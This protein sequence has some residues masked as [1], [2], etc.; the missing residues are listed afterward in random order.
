MANLS[1]KEIIVVDNTTIDAVFSENLNTS[2]GVSNITIVSDTPGV[3]DPT[4]S[5]VKV[6]NNSLRIRTTPIGY[7]STYIITFKSTSF[8]Q[9]SNKNKTA[10][11]PED[12]TNN[13]RQFQGPF[14]NDNAILQYLKAFFQDSI[15][16]IDNDQ[17]TTARLTQAY[18]KYL[19]KA[20]YDIRQV[21]N[22]NY[23]SFTVTDEQ[24]QRGN[25]PY[26][27]L[28]EEAAYEILRVG[29]TPTSTKSTLTVEYDEFPSY[30]ITLG[31]TSTSENLS[32]DS[33]DAPGKFNI[34]NFTL[35]LL[36]S[37]VIKLSSL[38]FTY[39]A[40]SYVYNVETY[41]YQL[42]NNKYAQDYGFKLYTLS[43]SQIKI[44]DKILED[45]NF[46][47]DGILNIQATYLYN[48]LG[49]EVNQNTLSVYTYFTQSREVI[50]PIVNTFQLTYAPIVGSG[51]LPGKIG[52]VTFID[53]N[54]TSSTA[55]HPAFLYEILYRLDF[56]PSKPGEYCVEYSTGKVYVYGE[57]YK[58][59]GT[60]PYPPL[61]TYTYKYDFKPEI[62]YVFD[63]QATGEENQNDFVAL[64]NGSLVEEHGIVTIEHEKVLV[65]NIDFV[66]NLHKESLNERIN[67]NLLS[68]SII[69]AAN[70]P[71]TNVFRVYNETSGEVYRIQRFEDDKIYVNYNNPPSILQQKR[72][73]AK[74]ET[75]YNELIF[76]SSSLTNASTIKVF[77]IL[78]NSSNLAS[79]S[80]DHI[81][82]FKNTPVA[83][84]KTEIFE[85]EKWYNT[86]LTETQN[87]N[88]LT[89]IGEYN[90]NYTDGILYIAV[91]GSQDYNLG[92]LS[93]KSSK[94]ELEHPHIISPDDIYTQINVLENKDKKYSYTSFEDKYILPSQLTISDEQFLNNDVLYPYQVDTNEIGV[95]D[96]VTF[97]AGVTDNIK[98]I[99]GIYEYQDILSSKSPFNFANYSTFTNNLITLSTATISSFD[100]VKYD[101]YDYYVELPQELQYISANITYTVSVIRQSDSAELWDLSGV[102]NT[103]D[104]VR[105]VLSG[106]NSPVVDQ[107]VSVILTLTI[108]DVSRVV[109]DYDKGELYLDYTYLNDEILINYEYGDNILD[110]RNS[111]SLTSGDIYYVSYKVGALRDALQRNFATLLNIDELNSLNIDFDR[112]RYR[113]AIYAAL[114]SFSQGPTLNAIKNIGHVISHI[115]PEV[116]ESI[117]QNWSLGNSLLNPRNIEVVGNFDLVPVKYGQGVLINDASQ[118]MTFPM[119]SNLKLEGGTFETWVLPQWYGLD[120]DGKLDFEI[121]KDGYDVDPLDIFLGANE[122]HPSSNDFSIEKKDIL[123]GIPNLNK[124]GVYIYYDRDST[125]SYYR[126]NVQ[127]IDGYIDGYSFGLKDYNINIRSNGNFYDVKSSALITPVN[128]KFTTGKNF[129]KYMIDDGYQINDGLTF[130]CDVDHYI[131]DVGKEYNKNR[132]S[133]F[134]DPSGYI[135]FRVYDKFGYSYNLSSDVSSW[136]PN[137]LHHI[138]ASWKLNT[139]NNKDEMHLFIDGTEVPNIIKYGEKVVP[140]LHQNFRTVSQE[141]LIALVN[142]DII[143]GTDLVTTS[144]LNTVS[145]LTNFGAYNILVGDTIHIDE[146]GFSTSGY[147]ISVIAGQNLTLSSSM[148]LSLTDGKFTINRTS[149][150]VDSQINIYPNIAV[151]TLSDFYTNT[152]GYVNTG[153]STITTSTNLAT[154]GVEAGNLVRL[155][156]SGPFE[157]FYTVVSVGG[158]NL[159]VN[160]TMPSTEAVSYYVYTTDETE[161]PGVRALS[162]SYEIEKDGYYNNI[163]TVNNNVYANDL[164]LLRT[165][166]LNH[167]RVRKT[168]YVWGNA[169]NFIPTHMPAPLSTDEVKITKV[170]LNTT[171]IGPTNSI[172]TLGEWISNN[173]DGYQPIN[174]TSGKTLS[175]T[176][177]GTNTNF[178]SPVQV[179]IDGYT[180]LTPVSEILNFTAY[181]TKDTTNLFTAINFFQVNATPIIT[182]KAACN[183]IV[184]EKYTITYME[185]D[186]YGPN[187]QFN[188]PIKTGTK[189]EY[190]SGT[191]VKD[192]YNFFSMYDVGNVLQ[193]FTPPS[194]AGYYMIDS[195]NSVH[196]TITLSSYNGSVLPLTN[197][198]N[199][200]YRIININHERSGYQNGFFY[201][202]DKLNPMTPFELSNGWYEFDYHTYAIIK[203][204]PMNEEV[205]FGSDMN[206]SNHFN[207]AFDQLKLYSTMLADTR[208]GE[209]IPNK[210]RSIT[211]DYNSV[212]AL[213]KDVNTTM[214]V[215]FDEAPFTNSADHY[216]QFANK[217]LI[218]TNTVI[219]DNFGNAAIFKDNGLVLDNDGI[220][221]T[222]KESSIEFWLNPLYDTINDPH[223]RYYFD[224]FG[225]VIEHVTS[226]NNVTISVNGNV[227]QVLSVKL[228]SDPETD[229]FAGGRVEISANEA[230]LEQVT[231]LSNM[232]A[233]VSKKILQVISVKI[234]GDATNKDYFAGGTIGSDKKTIYLGTALPSSSLSLNVLYKTVENSVLLNKQVIRLNKKLPS[235]NSRVVVTYLP[236]GLKGD[237]VSIFKDLSGYLNFRIIANNINY[238]IRTRAIF[239]QGTWHRVKATFKV[240]G[241]RNADEMRL[242]V[243]G[244][245]WSNKRFGT[246]VFS[247]YPVYISGLPYVGPT[248]ITGNI[249]FR[250]AINQ[251]FIGSE[252]TGGSTAYAL[253]DNLRI[254]NISRPSQQVYNEY[255]DVHYSKNLDVVYPVTEDLYT[256]YLLD[257]EKTLFKNDDFVTLRNRKNGLFDFYLN[258][259]DSFGIISSSNKVKSILEKLVKTLKPANSKGHI[260]YIT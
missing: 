89:S 2:I 105:F 225:A 256:T 15:Y 90:I 39:L 104:Q 17:N 38:T 6:K 154:Q 214:L 11:F 107:L 174:T 144:G 40:S 146:S 137:E 80:E 206:Q 213:K 191:S 246:L 165:L 3:P 207:G 5:E 54:A 153:S 195:V 8:I 31:Q 136:V 32:L 252:Y 211:K 91:S 186:G 53:P 192:G 236:K 159:V 162:P 209:S 113:D 260:N 124:D 50:D 71:I 232:S 228:E 139:K 27:R 68:P 121:L 109:V 149:Y 176:I 52:D 29:K 203:F 111:T 187:I 182:S 57:D 170:L 257:V 14:E 114:S 201:F 248:T 215:S 210:Q 108:N 216:I 55:K 133:I 131:L 99:R 151:S 193:V 59:N 128:N 62:D 64:P 58:N 138:A 22:E 185:S 253:V 172:L 190:V 157:P 245:E 247:S 230:I 204:D 94:I 161:I 243:D 178:S 158:T 48:D 35:N 23:I 218:Q 147:T 81:G 61:A 241:N 226:L 156:G 88:L 67:N 135:S 212:K 251:L 177:S 140:Y 198:S 7:L 69:R 188:Y 244:Y 65:P 36:N 85:T 79:L 200:L 141:E 110:F 70:G 115:E 66:S 93:Y 84:S 169:Q 101:G 12:G 13:V 240:N 78:L 34:K 118:K 43:N 163:L 132:I 25:G 250:D 106:V 30:P 197:F 18:S 164:L 1:I 16:D 231:S 220:L 229:Y 47:L 254:S 160:D 167:R 95:Y 103:G 235:Q 179:T 259:T 126:W 122:L 74:F 44:S 134:K 142:R 166:G 237:R 41:G 168:V 96:G 28:N 98:S 173:I 202:Y 37:P 181:G 100:F 72:E 56:L 33:E 143:S 102:I 180:G 21:K 171:A 145:S 20:L 24:K 129:V 208:I 77:K 233:I 238:Q 249:V 175:V 152:D 60:G 127:V 199:G 4:I 155:V 86:Y 75:V 42:L 26:D 196:D 46:S 119:N 234:V 120:N 82:F 97:V 224:A 9:F 117:F 112:E 148:P 76:V 49:V 45:S 150:N 19:S 87:I 221:N 183:I 125:N 223:V 227:G 51:N 63:D 184:K 116:I 222:R 73:R 189:L 205:Y 258:V 242:W 130:I 10:P 255:V 123:Y 194:A 239:N 83:F 92:T 219:N 217:N